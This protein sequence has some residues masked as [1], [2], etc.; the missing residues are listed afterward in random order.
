MAGPDGTSKWYE[1]S[2][3]M[4]PEA[5]AEPVAKAIAPATL[6]DQKRAAAAGSIIKPTAISVP[7][8]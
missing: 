7:S 1:I 4:T 6:S 5:M 8:A 2:K 3:P